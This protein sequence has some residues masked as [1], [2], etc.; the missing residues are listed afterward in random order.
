MIG[1]GK[2]YSVTWLDNITDR[3]SVDLP[4]V[5]SPHQLVQQWAGTFNNDDILTTW[6][7]NAFNLQTRRSI[8]RLRPYDSDCSLTSLWVL[9]K[10]SRST[11]WLFSDCYLSALTALLLL[12]D[13]ERRRL[14]AK[15]HFD[16]DKR[17]DG[18][19]DFFGSCQSKFWDT[20]QLTF[21]TQYNSSNPSSPRQQAGRGLKHQ[22]HTVFIKNIFCEP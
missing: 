13:L 7:R 3:W 15:E 19:S 9:S 5:M 8:Y 12:S 17:T 21:N 4:A 11:L 16:T 14:T 20:L 6:V 2:V 10:C 1:R 22:S 18:Q